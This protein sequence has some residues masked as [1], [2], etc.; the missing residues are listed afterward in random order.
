MG[1]NDVLL[2]FR[3]NSKNLLKNS[4]N[5]AKIS[6]FA[7]S[8]DDDYCRRPFKKAQCKSS[9]HQWLFQISMKLSQAKIEL[10]PLQQIQVKKFHCR[11]PKQLISKGLKIGLFHASLLSIQTFTIDERVFSLKHDS[12]FFCTRYQVLT[13]PKKVE[14]VGYRVF[15]FASPTQ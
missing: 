3:T 12:R 8:K 15:S 13:E 4:R 1:N 2:I 6:N 10:D 7:N 14:M 5:S 9:V 11:A